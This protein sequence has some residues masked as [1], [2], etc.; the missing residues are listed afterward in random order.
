M[1]PPQLT[2]A[3]LEASSPSAL[4]HLAATLGRTDLAVS[5]LR[6]GASPTDL[7]PVPD[8]VPPYSS[9]PLHAALS[10]SHLDVARALLAAGASLTAR[11]TL[12]RTPL[13]VATDS[14]AVRASLAAHICQRAAAGDAVAVADA[15]AAGFDLSEHDGTPAMNSPLHWAAAFGQ[16]DVVHHLLNAAVNPDANNAKG[17]T[18]LRDAASAGHLH[19]VRALLAAGA[20]PSNPNNEGS[21]PLDVAADDE[22]LGALH[23]ACNPPS[24]LSQIQHQPDD[25][26]KTD[27]QPT[28]PHTPYFVPG[29]RSRPTATP[30][31]NPPP[32]DR[33]PQWGSLLWP[34]P[35]RFIEAVPSAYFTL[36]PVVTISAETSCMSVARLLVEWLAEELPQ[37]DYTVRLVGGGHGGLGEAIAFSA[38]IFLRVDPHAVEFPQQAYNLTVRDFGLDAVAVDVPGLFY[39]CATLVNV[40]KLRKAQ[41]EDP[42]APLAIP[43]FRI[44]DWPSIM[45]RALYLDVSGRRLPTR[46]T[47]EKLVRFL[48]RHLK[49]NQLQLHLGNN[50]VRMAN[51]SGTDALRHEDILTLASICRQHFVEL[52]PVVPSSEHGAELSVEN[53]DIHANGKSARHYTE[54]RKN[55]QVDNEKLYDEFITLFDSPQ[56]HLGDLSEN[57]KC[58][59]ADFERLRRA[60]SS[61][62]ARGKQTVQVFGDK[63]TDILAH[64]TMSSGVLAEIPTRCIMILQAT[65]SSE[66]SFRESCLRMRQHGLPFYTC[67]SSCLDESLAGSTSECIEL[68]RIAVETGIDQGAVGILMKDRSAS[69]QGAPLVFL[70]QSLVPFAGASWNAKQTIGKVTPG[71]DDLLSHLFDTY[72]FGD[73]I[74]KGILGNI[75]LSLGD[76]HQIAGD[77]NGTGLFHLLSQSRGEADSSLEAMTYLGLRRALKRAERIEIALAS[78]SGSAADTDVHEL[79]VTAI[80]LGVSARLGASL[81]SISSANSMDSTR[82]I[83]DGNLE[84]NSLPDGRRSDLCNA[85]LQGIELLRDAWIERYFEDGFTD[86]VELMTGEALARLAD[87]MP[88]QKYLEERKADGWAPGDEN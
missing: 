19:I 63:V 33:R 27:D 2:E 1:P 65:S 49:M 7:T 3:D 11:D 88:Y 25:A 30:Q 12:S 28:T 23:R 40:V 35:Q 54:N 46:R 56:V 31:R 82:S 22:I 9:T 74:N 78:Y 61:L 83:S 51:V 58:D 68:S 55:H 64:A 13:D 32:K 50:F 26:G 41:A 15:A 8:T 79:R 38:S 85:L 18:P 10:S 44:T 52:V 84:I 70:Y 36:P 17:D 77:K 34:R 60:T 20:D 45:R 47:L 81:F 59:P 4:L 6:A 86:T 39:A 5:A 75:A 21:S 66:D 14:P 37:P 42:T 71:P 69:T 87:G 57:Q 16:I 53:L 80:L 43:T 29:E 48:A 67:A 62:R 73:P 72:I 76:L 24:S